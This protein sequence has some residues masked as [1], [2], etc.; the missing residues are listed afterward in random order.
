[1][2][3]AISELTI[4]FRNSTRCSKKVIAPAGSASGATMAASATGSLAISAWLLVM[5]GVLG[6]CGNRGR[7]GLLSDLLL[8]DLLLFAPRHRFRHRRDHRRFGRPMLRIRLRRQGLRPRR[9]ALRS[10]LWRSNRSGR[11]SALRLLALIQNRLPLDCAHLFFK[12]AL[13]IPR[14]LAELR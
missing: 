4:R 6:V 11:G 12:R 5:G 13:E 7:L 1:M 3:I 9:G 2:T 10:R 8:F 14:R